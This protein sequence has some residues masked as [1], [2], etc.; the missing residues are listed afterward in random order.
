MDWGLRRRSAKRREELR[1]QGE[2]DAKD[3]GAPE[4]QVN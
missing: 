3:M 1:K 2:G 4:G